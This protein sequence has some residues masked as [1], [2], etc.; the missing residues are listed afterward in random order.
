MQLYSSTVAACLLFMLP[1]LVNQRKQFGTLFAFM[2]VCALIVFYA[3][4]LLGAAAFMVVAYLAIR[5]ILRAGAP[6]LEV[7]SE[8]EREFHVLA[9]CTVLAVVLVPPARAVL[10][11]LFL[12]I[13]FLHA[14]AIVASLLPFSVIIALLLGA[15][16]KCRTASRPLPNYVI[17]LLA[18]VSAG[19]V[20]AISFTI[21]G[22][23]E[24][25]D[26]QR[27][28][29][30]FS[31]HVVEQGRF[32]PSANYCSCNGLCNGSFIRKASNRNSIGAVVYV[33]LASVAVS[34]GLSNAHYRMFG[35]HTKTFPV[36]FRSGNYFSAP[37]NA[38]D[39]P[40]AA[41]RETLRRTLD[42][43]R[44]RSITISDPSQYFA[45]TGPFLSQF[46]QQR[47]LDG[48]PGLPKALAELPWPP[49]IAS[50]RSLTFRD[51]K[52]LP[53]DLL[54][55]LGVKYALPVSEAIYF[56]VSEAAR[57]GSQCG[58]E[59]MVPP[60]EN[61]Y[62]PIPRQFFASS[63]RSPSL[64]DSIE[65][66]VFGLRA[67]AVDPGTAEIEWDSMLRDGNLEIQKRAKGAGKFERVALL[68]PTEATIQRVHG[69]AP[70]GTYEFRLRKHEARGS[71]EVY[72]QPVVLQ[73]PAIRS[74]PPRVSGVTRESDSSVKVHWDPQPSAIAMRL[75]VRRGVLEEFKLVA[76]VPADKGFTRLML[77]EPFFAKM[78]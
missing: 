18:L 36:A 1:F 44:Y 25:V 77:S 30:A 37:S 39:V 48:Y 72:T 50:L 76:E 23:Q 75:E 16:G 78:H 49:G 54:A 3:S 69:L 47:F 61:P 57:N 63:A 40:S 52:D 56:N 33:V 27:A 74:E 64:K 62:I 45:Y 9:L 14:R 20:S 51:T 70:G 6:V 26:Q 60:V 13:D 7:N 38:F 34:E 43:D 21:S 58:F 31:L 73:L 29:C 46:W 68:S 24:G 28:A 67:R 19:F 5:F 8:T 17:V 4:H 65:T 2:V 35:E 42:A 55:I 11:I 41:C 12:K 66:S 53:W 15:I 10:H 22:W 59:N 32:D 71:P